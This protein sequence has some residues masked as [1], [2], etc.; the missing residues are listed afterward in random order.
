MRPSCYL[1]CVQYGAE[2]GEPAEV[3]KSSSESL[4]TIELTQ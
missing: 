3:L 2:D 4:L 1:Q